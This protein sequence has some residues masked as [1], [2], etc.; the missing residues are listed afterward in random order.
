MIE[1]RNLTL[2]YEQRPAVHHL[3]GVI[4]AGSLTAIVGPNGS[5]KSTLLR[6]IA[7][8]ISPLQGEILLSGISGREIGYLPQQ[9]GFDL[10]FPISVREFVGLGRIAERGIFQG[11]Q[12]R[13][14]AAVERAIHEVQLES[15]R[16]RN[17]DALSGGQVQRA[18]FARLSAQGSELLLLDEPF[19]HLDP[20]TTMDL[21]YL[22]KRW[23]SEGK[24]ILVVMH[25][26][27]L[28]R[29]LCPDV[30]LLAREMIARGPADQVLTKEN[31]E[32]A[33]QKL[34]NPTVPHWCEGPH[35][36]P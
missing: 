9:P 20:R 2:G 5:G 32:L 1:F 8:L 33:H 22:V 17:L 7:G 30:L 19:S 24:T 29:Q 18:R 34:Q 12:E 31:F 28:A 4:R 25:E 10:Q 36:H 13:D 23:N 27:H 26:I 14:Y 15:V 21:V 6:G 35:E 16:D 11:L 3:N